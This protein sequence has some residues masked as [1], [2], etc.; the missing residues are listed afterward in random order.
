M[1]IKNGEYCHS[2]EHC[3][4]DVHELQLCAPNVTYKLM[5][6]HL[7]T[8]PNWQSCSKCQHCVKE[9]LPLSLHCTICDYYSYSNRLLEE[10]KQICHSTIDTLRLSTID[11]GEVIPVKNITTPSSLNLPSK[12]DLPLSNDKE[13]MLCSS[14]VCEQYTKNLETQVNFLKA[15]LESKSKKLRHLLSVEAMVAK[16]KVQI[17]A[18]TE[19]NDKLN[20]R[21]LLIC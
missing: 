15:Q 14:T 6:E 12:H 3:H 2:C 20:R 19:E 21:Q 17:K 18:L 10:H 4:I 1:A 16:Q 5:G 7:N 13:P 8:I 9:S 11:A